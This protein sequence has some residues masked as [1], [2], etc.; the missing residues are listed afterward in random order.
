MTRLN[1]PATPV[2]P[3]APDPVD[4]WL[5]V[6]VAMLS[7]PKPDRQRV[8]DELEDHLRSRID[9]LLI[10]GLTEPQA[11]QKAV[12]E[13]G[14]TADLARQLS[15]AHKPPRTRR[16][17]MH[18]LIIALAGTVV[19]LGVTTTRTSNPIAVSSNA[20]DTQATNPESNEAEAGPETKLID[21]DGAGFRD[22]FRTVTDAF[23]LVPGLS[24]TMIKRYDTHDPRV[25]IKGT[26]T[27][28]QSMDRLISFDP[29][30]SE[31]NAY[32]IDG[33][34]VVITDP[35]VAIRRS[36]VTRTYNAGSVAQRHGGN[37]QLSVSNAI[38]NSAYPQF[39][40][41]GIVDQALVVTGRPE[42]QE[43]AS[44]VLQDLIA[45]EEQAAA[46]DRATRNK[47]IQ[48]AQADIDEL[49]SD[50]ENFSGEW[51][52]IAEEV[53]QLSVMLEAVPPAELGKEQAD[54]RSSIDIARFHQAE[55]LKTLDSIRGRLDRVRQRLD[56]I[57]AGEG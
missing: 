36:I 51:T 24:A 6:L 2:H 38:E 19:A 5:D 41:V 25:T 54:L 46:A 50:Y 9:D 15:H 32:Y 40:H 22:A 3:S 49:V 56:A 47:A 43:I 52:R 34:R 7:I 18:A 42:A 27:F 26:Y 11:L 13:L 37:L 1:K 29:Y 30:G 53:A 45:A 8:R 17:A 31:S 14:E 44:A 35:M 21:I 39:A 23:G 28:E 57:R 55:V 12:A 4:A 20:V 16:F 48:E 33:D 10:H